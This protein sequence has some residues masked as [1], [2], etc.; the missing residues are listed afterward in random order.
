MTVSKQSQD[1]I[2]VISASGWLFKN[3]ASLLGLRVRIPP[4]AWMYVS[5]EYCMLSGRGLCDRPIPRP[6]E[7]YRYG[8][9]P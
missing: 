4:R 2:G 5:C 7:I 9:S 6:E 1:K 3:A 8:A